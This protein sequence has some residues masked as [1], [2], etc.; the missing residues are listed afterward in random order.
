LQKE[1]Q[2][3]VPVLPRKKNDNAFLPAN[4]KNDMESVGIEHQTSML[5]PHKGN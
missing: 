4:E 3:P 1:K 2:R 5:S